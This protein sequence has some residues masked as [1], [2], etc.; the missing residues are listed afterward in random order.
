MSARIEALAEFCSFVGQEPDAIIGECAR[1]VEGGKRIRI[2]KRR[3]YSE[4]IDEFQASVDGDARTQT[5]AGNV[6]RS[7]M[8]HNGIFMQ[9]G[10]R[11]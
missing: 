4:K 6:I 8:I 1:E 2:K 10:V 11:G 7:F 9:G 5:R 3:F